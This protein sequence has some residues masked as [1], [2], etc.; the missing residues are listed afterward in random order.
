MVDTSMQP[1]GWDLADALDD[2]WTPKQLAA[3][4]RAR[5][6]AIEIQESER[7]AV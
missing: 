5:V 6:R 3:W 7:V 4:A 2:G 1:K